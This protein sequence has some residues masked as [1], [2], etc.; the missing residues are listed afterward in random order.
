MTLIRRGRPAST[1]ASI[2]APTSLTC[3]C[4]FQ[5]PSPV[6]T[7]ATESPSAT[8]VGTNVRRAPR[9]RHRAGTGP[10]RR[11]RSL[12]RSRAPRGVPAP[13]RRG[14]SDRAGSAPVTCGPAR[15]GQDEAEA[16]GVDHAGPGQHG[17]LLGGVASASAAAAYAAWTHSLQRTARRDGV[18]GGADHRQDRPGDGC[19][20]GVPG[21][22]R[23]SCA[24]PWPRSPHRARRHRRPHRRS[25][26]GSATESPR[27][28]RARRARRRAPV[29]AARC[30]PTR[31]GPRSGPRPPPAWSRPCWC[32]CRRPVPG[33]RS[34]RRSRPGAPAGVST[35]ARLQRRTA[36]ASSASSTSTPRA[37][38]R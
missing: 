20:D 25:R 17:E 23:A 3:T 18:G 19:G 37:E 6:P 34:T 9:R 15:R 16:A 7:T 28:C 21:L 8:S 35:A 38:S 33:R 32:R 22:V 26:A 4:T 29:P 13:S 30:P 5:V 24:T 2:A 31:S 11:T 14:G 36:S 10:R 1:P 27:S 12:P